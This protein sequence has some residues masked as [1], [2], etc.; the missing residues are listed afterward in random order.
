VVQVGVD[1]LGD[2]AAERVY[3]NRRRPGR[4]PSGL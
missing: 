1:I 3:P 4:P 2:I